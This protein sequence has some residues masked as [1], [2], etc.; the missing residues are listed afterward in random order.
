M[1]DYEKYTKDLL[2]ITP[3]LRFVFGMRD[4]AT[5]SHYENSL[6]DEYINQM[7]KYIEKYRDTKDIELQIELFL[8]EIEI[9]YKFYLLLF[10]SQANFILLF[11]YMSDNIYP[12][13][14][15]YKQARIKDFDLYVNTTIVRAKEGLRLKITYPKII[16]KKFM[17]Q[18]KNLDK[19]KSLYQFIKRDYYPYCRTEIGLCYIPNGKEIYKQIIKEYIGFLDLTPEEIHNTGLSLI[20]KKINGSET[21]KSK[22]ELLED[23]LYYSNYI[24]THIIEKYFHYKMES[25]FEIS[26]M[27]EDLTDS[28]PLAYF[29]DVEGKVFI[30]LSYYNEVNKNEI[31]SLLMHECFHFYH[32]KF[33]KY[34]KIPKYKIYIY[35]NIALVEGFAHYMEIYCE[36]YDDDNNSYSLLRKLRLVL[37]TGINY[38]G[39]TYK[40]SFDFM[41]KYLPNRKTDNINEI[42]RCICMP[43]QSLSYLTGKLHII[44]LRDSYLAS[45][46]NIKDFHHKLLINGLASF[47]T[48]DKEFN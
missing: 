4:K 5:L 47:K 36:D 39:W 2:K 12:K 30:N 19:Y 38:Y 33:M 9:K 11:N 46:G 21:Y 48:I 17:D 24:Y 1:K 22:E 29:D 45:G 32:F 25:P 28:F 43:G 3:S 7:Q 35:S 15:A 31:Y 37:D 20:K 41:N 13:N 6:S 42:D 40:Q 23:C 26:P 18:I 27:S 8:N 16:I 10:A 34:Y 44:K 14:E